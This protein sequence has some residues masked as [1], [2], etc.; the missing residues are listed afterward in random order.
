MALLGNLIWF[1]FLGGF[2][3]N[4]AAYRAAHRRAA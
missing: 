2:V 3:P 1:V 4:G